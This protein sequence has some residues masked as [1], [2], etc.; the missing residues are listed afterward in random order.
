M[1]AVVIQTLF[2]CSCLY[3]VSYTVHTHGEV[4][5]GDEMIA[6]HQVGNTLT[7]LEEGLHV[8]RNKVIQKSISKYFQ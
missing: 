4:V 8:Y 6:A 3:E 1:V 5:H 2:G 7:H